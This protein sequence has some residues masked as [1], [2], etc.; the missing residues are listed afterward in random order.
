MK[1]MM[2]FLCCISLFLFGGCKQTAPQTRQTV[3]FDTPC[4]ITL[5]E[6]GNEG[7]L[8]ECMSMIA[9][10]NELWSRTDP[11]SVVSKLNEANGKTIAQ[12]TMTVDLLRKAIAWSK[13]TNGA[14]DITVLPYTQLWQDAQ[15]TGVVPS[16]VAIDSVKG[17]V[18]IENVVI[19]QDGVKLQNDAQIDLGGIAKGYVADELVAYLKDVGC[20]SAIIDLG[21]NVAVI[22]EKPDGGAFRVGIAHPLHE[23]ELIATVAVR[24]CSVVTSGSYI[25]GFTVGDK[26]YS[27]IID[28]RTGY[29]VDNDLLSVTIVCASAAKADALSTACFVMGYEKAKDFVEATDGVEAVFVK[30]DETV[31]AT[32]G[33]T[34][35]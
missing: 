3:A 13:L 25:R 30:T 15:K 33:V 11:H 9:D 23:N 17:T 5:Y 10:R 6:G 24:D 16:Q 2:I 31:V 28:P 12:N 19:D 18:G 22:G 34:L 14:F 20:T 35:V 1:R 8:D 29:P 7:W 32:A 21:G 4:T 26:R 27:H